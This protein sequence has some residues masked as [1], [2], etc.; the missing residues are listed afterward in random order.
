M[1]ML[2]TLAL[3]ASLRRAE[4][5]TTAKPPPVWGRLRAVLGLAHNA[6]LTSETSYDDVLQDAA[7]RYSNS[8]RRVGKNERWFKSS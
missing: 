1:K 4:E 3:A 5:A 2:K 6:K 7:I 8:T